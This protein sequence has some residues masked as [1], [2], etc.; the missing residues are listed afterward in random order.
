MFVNLASHMWQV[1]GLSTDWF[2]IWL[3]KLCSWARDT[4]TLVQWL[5]GLCCIKFAGTTKS[6]LH[7]GKEFELMEKE[8]ICG[9]MCA[10][11]LLLELSD[12]HGWS[13]SVNREVESEGVSWGTDSHGWP[14]SVNREVQPEE[15]SWGTKPSGSEQES[16]ETSGGKTDML[17]TLTAPLIPIIACKEQQKN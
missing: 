13:L 3:L 15:V 1:N 12:L 4:P 7:M 2:S 6:L 11:E 5:G 16:M 10:R 17:L 14:L 9:S 8:N